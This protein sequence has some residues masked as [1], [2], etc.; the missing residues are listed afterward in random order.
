MLY[1]LG[2]ILLICVRKGFL[3]NLFMMWKLVVWM[4]FCFEKFEMMVMWLMVLVLF[5]Y[6]YVLF[7]FWLVICFGNL[8]WV[9]VFDIVLNFEKIFNNDFMLSWF[10]SVLLLSFFF[11]SFVVLVVWVNNCDIC[12]SWS[13]WCLLLECFVCVFIFCKWF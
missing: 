13:F 9:L 7:L 5:L 1:V 10:G 2:G 3:S 12:F 8:F 4:K 6:C 11:Y